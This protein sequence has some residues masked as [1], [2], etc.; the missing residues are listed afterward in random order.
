MSFRVI[1][2]GAGLTG[3]TAARSLQ[4]LGAKVHVLEQAASITAL[5]ERGL[6]LWPQ[7]VR[8]LR[9]LFN[10][11]ATFDSHAHFLPPAAYR[12]RRD[13]VWL[14][15][16]SDGPP[17][18]AGRAASH[19]R[20]VASMRQSTLLALLHDDVHFQDGVGDGPPL[21]LSFR[22]GVTGVVEQGRFGVA[23]RFAD[24]A[25]SEAVDM[26]V[27]ADGA[28]SALGRALAA[29]AGAAAT[30][31]ASESGYSVASGTLTREQLR[32]GSG[33]ELLRP[34][35][36][37]ETLD[38]GGSGSAGGGDSDGNIGCGIDWQR[39]RRRFAVVPLR[40]GGLFWFAH[41]P[42]PALVAALG[43]ES[44]GCSAA[45]RS[46]IGAMFADYHDPVPALLACALKA[47]ADNSSGGGIRWEEL[48]CHRGVGGNNGSSAEPVLSLRGAVPPLWS[49]GRV[50]LLGDALQTCSANLAQGAALGI[51]DAVELASCVDRARRETGHGELWHEAAFEDFRR[52]RCGRRRQHAQLTAF[53]EALANP[54]SQFPLSQAR[55]A[56][57]LAS[58]RDAL[59]QATPRSLNGF[60]FDKCLQRSLG[61][62]LPTDLAF[63]RARATES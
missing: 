46:A 14:S 52:Q 1:V 32:E 49:C 45:A 56:R 23:V 54:A 29:K 28:R 12:S 35:W 21:R 2:V 9:A 61:G 47:D 31:T 63:L 33:T 26:V 44:P 55:M 15:R 19:L 7:A 39:W 58:W 38:D 40:D 59:L 25:L 6:G 34:D 36:A 22:Q 17:D 57:F 60:I 42:T 41:M 48:V 27:G 43:E 18:D 16:C 5:P 62:S 8:G 3:M 37:Y 51:E 53:T 4:R 13:G 10:T 24:G 30:V 50:V 11:P 20:M